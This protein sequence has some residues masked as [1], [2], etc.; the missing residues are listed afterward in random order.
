VF[1]RRHRPSRTH[2]LYRVR[3][4]L[5]HVYASGHGAFARFRVLSPLYSHLIFFLHSRT[6][7]TA[8]RSRFCSAVAKWND[9]WFSRCFDHVSTSSLDGVLFL[10]WG[11]PLL[12]LG[13]FT[14]VLLPL[15]GRVRFGFQTLRVLG[16]V[17]SYRAHTS[18]D[19]LYLLLPLGIAVP[20]L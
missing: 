11:I 13:P 9:F 14:S 1:T 18:F 20:R 17:R 15:R 16:A 5:D 19:Y 7:Q 6:C 3:D 12:L 4:T 8:P 2:A 10:G